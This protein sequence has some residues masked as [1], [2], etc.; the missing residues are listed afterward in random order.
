MND[1]EINE[2][3]KAIQTIVFRMVCDFDDY[4]KANNITYFLSGGTC[5]G[6]VR[7]KGFIP[8]DD[9]ADL[10][11]PRPD[12]EKFIQNFGNDQ[13]GKYGLASLKTDPSWHRPASRI[14]DEGTIVEATKFNERTIGVFI[15]IF[16]I[17]GLPKGRLRQKFFYLRLK[18]LNVLRNASIR[19]EFWDGE[20][21]QTAKRLLAILAKRMDARK[22]AVRIDNIARRYSFAQSE[23]VAA[24]LAVH[25]WSR[26]TIKRECMTSAIELPFEGRM[27]PVPVGY[28]TYLKNLYG[29]YMEIPKEAKEKG[30][31]HMEGY[32]V[33][34]KSED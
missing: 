11:M 16:P 29:N 33:I 20:K 19:K 22:L 5:L 13:Q 26:E 3:V 32:K 23:E 9:D 15:D 7:H 21:L 31:T 10:M 8:W 1:K 6:A 24:S 34:L 25:Y 2:Q 28:D 12:Y 30:F 14:W 4:C 27:L 17:D 18:F